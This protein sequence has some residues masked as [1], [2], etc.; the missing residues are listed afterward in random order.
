MEALV[1]DCDAL[2][3]EKRA[4]LA[5]D[6]SAAES[7]LAGIKAK[8]RKLLDAYL[9]GTVPSEV[10]QERAEELKVMRQG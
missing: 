7:E 4:E 6:V 8:E 1:A 5:P 2:M 3:Q 9:D 10:Y